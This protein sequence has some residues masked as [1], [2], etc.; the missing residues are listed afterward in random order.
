[1]FLFP[2]QSSDYKMTGQS[3][4][5]NDGCSVYI[6][7]ED[8]KTAKVHHNEILSNVRS[9]INRIRNSCSKTNTLTSDENDAF[10]VFKH[11]KI[12]IQKEGNFK[13]TVL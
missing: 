3:S 11:E 1:M 9:I 5:H 10:L 2:L 4:A 13:I 6:Y 12:H 8:G 7:I